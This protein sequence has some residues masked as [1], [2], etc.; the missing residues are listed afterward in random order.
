[1]E[2]SGYAAQKEKEGYAIDICHGKYGTGE[3][4]KYIVTIGKAKAVNISPYFSAYTPETNTQIVN[5]MGRERRKPLRSIFAIR[6]ATKKALEKQGLEGIKVAVKQIKD[7]EG[8]SDAEI[9]C[10]L[11]NRDT[12]IPYELVIHPIH[13]YTRK[14]NLDATIQ[15]EIRHIKHLGHASYSDKRGER[16]SRRKHRGWKRAKVV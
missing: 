11:K 14:G 13:Q 16:F 10:K 1:M 9:R 4:K 7:D 12:E 6:E 8:Y 5:R 3:R 2:A 15:H